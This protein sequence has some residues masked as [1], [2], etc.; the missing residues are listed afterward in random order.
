MTIFLVVALNLW[1]WIACLTS[2][3]FW[4]KKTKRTQ[5]PLERRLIAFGYGLAWPALLV[6]HFIN[7]KESAQIERVD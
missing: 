7:E 6:G 2:F 3:Y 5:A 1:W 4:A